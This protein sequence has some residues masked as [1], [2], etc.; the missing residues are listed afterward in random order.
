MRNFVQRNNPH[1]IFKGCQKKLEMSK[2]NLKNIYKIYVENIHE[3]FQNKG[4]IK[5]NCNLYEALT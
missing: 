2:Q 1:N 4:R 5:I 3:L